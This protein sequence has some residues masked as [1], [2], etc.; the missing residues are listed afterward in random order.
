MG[1]MEKRPLAKKYAIKNTRRLKTNE[2]ERK[3]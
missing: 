2:I 1:L 3:A